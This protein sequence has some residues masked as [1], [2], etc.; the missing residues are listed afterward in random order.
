M[1]TKQNFKVSVCMI[2]YGHESYIKQAIE[3]VLM[4]NCNFE[5]ELIIADDCSPDRT[6]TIVN[7]IKSTHENGYWIRYKKHKPNK[8][9]IPNF[10]W[11]LKECKG[12]YIALCE[13]DDYW[14]DPL[15]LQKQVDFL[16][17][18]NDF[19][20]IASNSLIV[21]EGNKKESHHFKRKIKKTLTVDDMLET[22]HFHTATYL[23]K[24]EFF[25]SDFP[26]NVLSGDRTLFLLLSCFGKTEVLPE[27]TAVYRKNEGGVSSNV[28]S[29]QM[30]KDFNML[31]FIKKYN[32]NETVNFNKLKAF[33]AYTVLSYSH[34]IKLQHFIKASYVLIIAN[35][36]QQSNIEKGV[37]SIRKSLSLI[38]SLHYKVNIYE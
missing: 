16:E 8:G 2:T 24:S 1:N 27:I 32:Y 14:T 35:L 20:A 7:E 5:V 15:K 29:E 6:Q 3:G 22:R 31:S 10:V 28:V 26:L 21:Y 13:G 12:K 33:L 30:M 25:K 36:K 34:S 23:F 37:K 11:T 9:M 4:Q 17:F 38:K 19:S 18:N